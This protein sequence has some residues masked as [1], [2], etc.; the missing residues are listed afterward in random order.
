[1]INTTTYDM[2][3]A[4][5]NAMVLDLCDDEL[6]MEV[7]RPSK[8]ST[9]WQLAVRREYRKRREVALRSREPR[10]RIVTNTM[11]GDDF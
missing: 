8:D 2:G 4:I 11:T 9:T 3:S 7:E 10:M 5:V 6:S 1:M